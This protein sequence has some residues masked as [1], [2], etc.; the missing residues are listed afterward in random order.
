MFTISIKTDFWVSKN[1]C[2]GHTYNILITMIKKF[3]SY[4]Y[5]SIILHTLSVV[6]IFAALRYYF[7]NTLLF[8]SSIIGVGVIAVFYRHYY[9]AYRK[10]KANDG[11]KVFQADYKIEGKS[12]Y[13]EFIRS[14]MFIA[15]ITT[16][17]TLY[18]ESSDL[19][20]VLKNSIIAAMLVFV[21]TINPKNNTTD[22]V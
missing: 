2:G 11:L 10:F 19:G 9:Y 18:K 16:F 7:N 6:A 21:A 20:Q 8:D 14:P 13:S 1:G 17:L 22:E 5:K 4:N 12:A 3:L 15:F